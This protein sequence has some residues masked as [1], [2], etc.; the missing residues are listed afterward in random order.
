MGCKTE[1]TEISGIEYT[2]TQYS[3]FDGMKYKM[4]VV[5]V[6]GPA[7]SKLLP[8]LKDGDNGQLEAVSNAVSSLFNAASPDEIVELIKEMLTNGNVRIGGEPIN[9]SKLIAQFSGDNL[10]D[11]YKLF[12]FV[13]RVNYAGFFKGQKAGELLTKVE[14]NL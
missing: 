9:E 6:I 4:R 12:I 10:V 8:A 14:E 1:T 13:L 2:C 7:I 11:I 5:K 3:A